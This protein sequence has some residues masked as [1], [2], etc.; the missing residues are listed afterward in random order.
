M[1]LRKMVRRTLY[2]KAT[3]DIVADYL[4]WQVVND[5]ESMLEAIGLEA[6]SQISFWDALV[7]SQHKHHE[8]RC[9]TQRTSRMGS[10][11]VRVTNPFLASAGLPPPA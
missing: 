1:N 7:V 4:T 10:A 3:R 8:R 9:C 5:G 11:T 2:A 6:R